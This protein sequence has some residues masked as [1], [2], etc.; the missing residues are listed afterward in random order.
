LGDS[1]HNIRISVLCDNS[2]Y[3][4]ETATGTYDYLHQRWYNSQVNLKHHPEFG[5]E[6]YR[7]LGD[8]KALIY[9][10]FKRLAMGKGAN[11][12]SRIR[13]V[14]EQDDRFYD[15]W[16]NYNMNGYLGPKT[17]NVVVSKRT[18]VRAPG[19][20]FIF[21]DEGPY[22]VTGINANGLNDTHLWPIMGKD[23]YKGALKR[24]GNKRNV[25]LRPDGY[26]TF[27]E[28]IGGFHYSPS[29]DPT[30]GKGNCTFADGHVAPV[31][32]DETFAVAWPK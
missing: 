30:T 16:H 32:R 10:T 6:F 17:R 29:G 7:Y 13:W 3:P 15:P 26:G 28:I 12:S 18:Q 25:K 5:S 8:V 4:G 20:V 1:E 27:V 31:F 23:N 2:K 9:P 24:F 11:L 22:T 21:A 19:D 14:G